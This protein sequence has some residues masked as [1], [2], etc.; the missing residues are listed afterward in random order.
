[1]EE[2]REGLLALTM[3]TFLYI[4]KNQSKWAKKKYVKPL[5]LDTA[6][7]YFFKIKYQPRTREHIAYRVISS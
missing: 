3:T 2:V 5:T 4:K 7:I 1:V 6:T